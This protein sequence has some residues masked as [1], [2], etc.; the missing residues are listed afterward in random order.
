[1]NDPID[2]IYRLVGRCQQAVLPDSPLQ[3]AIYVHHKTWL[4][5][6]TAKLP[7]GQYVATTPVVPYGEPTL[8]GYPLR[9]DP[10]VP[11][12]DVQIRYEATISVD[13]EGDW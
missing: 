10:S 8:F 1:M 2:E 5:L 12:G 7:G 4:V 11:P 9:R 3:G 13:M 6:V